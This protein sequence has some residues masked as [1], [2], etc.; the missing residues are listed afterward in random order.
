LQFRA[1]SVMSAWL[2]QWVATTNRRQPV[3][4]SMYGD[5]S[6]FVGPTPD[7]TYPMEMDSI[8]LP[9]ALT[10]TVTTDPIPA[11]AQDP[12]K[13]YAASLAKFNNQSYGES[14][15]LRQK[16]RD[17]LLEVSGAYQ[18]RVPNIYGA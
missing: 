9:T 12:I 17:R 8:I 3:V 15:T 11:V 2:R 1:F 18:R 4:W 13:F 10:D 16:Y 6:I 5:T 7:Q 14:E